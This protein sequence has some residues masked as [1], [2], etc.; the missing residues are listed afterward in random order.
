MP[1]QGR[2]LN[3]NIHPWIPSLAWSFVASANITYRLGPLSSLP[4]LL[5][6]AWSAAL[7]SSAH[8]CMRAERMRLRFPVF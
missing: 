5:D 2:Y 7:I 3:R 1:W 8:F 6:C 4:D